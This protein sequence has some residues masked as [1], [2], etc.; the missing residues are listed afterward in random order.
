MR[1]EWDKFREKHGLHDFTDW[2]SHLES[3]ASGLRSHIKSNQF[4]L[5]YLKEQTE[6]LVELIS[7]RPTPIH[8]TKDDFVK[9]VQGGYVW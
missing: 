9:N 5:D 3:V 1:T 2:L 8:K 7:V 4:D 6:Y